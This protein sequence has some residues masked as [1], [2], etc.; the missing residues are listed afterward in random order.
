[1]SVFATLAFAALQAIAQVAV[2][3][4]FGHILA[5]KGYLSQPLQKGLSV[6][7]VKFFTPCLLFA[8]TAASVNRD[9]F[10]QLW[11]LPIYFILF[12]SAAWLLAKAA[13]RPLGLT[14]AQTRF[15]ISTLMFSNTNSLP[16]GLIESL[17][18]SGAIAWLRWHEDDK[19]SLIAARGIAYIVFYSILGNVVRWSYGAH[20]L[21]SDLDAPTDTVQFNSNRSTIYSA[22]YLTKPGK[23]SRYPSYESNQSNISLHI[24]HH[25]DCANS[26]DNANERQSLLHPG[27]PAALAP[28]SKTRSAPNSAALDTDKLILILSD[29]STPDRTDSESPASGRSGSRRY[30]DYGTSLPNSTFNSEAPTPVDNSD[31]ECDAVATSPISPGRFSPCS[32][33]IRRSHRPPPLNLH[34]DSRGSDSDSLYTPPQVHSE[35]RGLLVRRS[36]RR[37]HQ[38]RPSIHPGRALRRMGRRLRRVLKPIHHYL[39]P[40]LTAPFLAALLGLLVALS[41]LRDLLIESDGLLH[42][43][44]FSAI[45]SCGEAAVPVILVCLGA[46]L[47]TLAQHRPAEENDT[48]ETSLL[49]SNGIPLRRSY[50]SYRH[51]V[52]FVIF[53]RLFL[54]PAISLAIVWVTLPFAGGLRDDPMFL[55]TVLLIGACPTAIN[56]MT[57]CQ[58]NGHFERPM[59]RV[60]MWEYLLSGCSMVCWCVTFLWLASKHAV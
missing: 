26:G 59:G 44:L 22:Q 36:R 10:I 23:L 4:S 29:E 60:L 34:S 8:N 24:T 41:P 57:V 37:S 54:L 42:A 55:F 25:D 7:S 53:S 28:A 45:R 11:P 15:V 43:T 52:P 31:V 51:V 46:Q 2:I 19:N 16:I 49:P 5:R 58:A 35:T 17:T 32:G 14:V 3:C 27:R 56:L 47:T 48:F 20:L 40:V 1:M 21:S 33:S 9:N 6:L 38:R 39:K 50:P 30:R 12:S 13:V 18:M